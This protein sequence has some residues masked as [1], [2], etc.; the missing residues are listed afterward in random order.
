MRL[1]K[2]GSRTAK[3]IKNYITCFKIYISLKII[4]MVIYKILDE[5][6][7]KFAF[8]RVQAMNMLCCVF[9]AQMVKR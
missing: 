9:F 3:R 2:S 8:I 5:L 6:G 4:C 7:N 1:H